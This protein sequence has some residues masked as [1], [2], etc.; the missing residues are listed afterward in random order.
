MDWLNGGST[1]FR[2]KSCGTC[3]TPISTKK[4]CSVACQ[5]DFEWL[6]KKGLVIK[7]EGNSSAV[8]RY[9][10]EQGHICN[11]CKNTIWNNV[12]IPLE[13]EHK[14]G[15]SKNNSLD[16]TELLCPNCHA[17]TPTYKNRN[18]GNGRAS[19]RKRYAEGKSY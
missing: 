8:K 6:Q 17:L 14:D 7:G 11:C 16:N 9:L 12:P 4:Y 15:N 5:K 1:N 2:S 19:R 18:R 3:Q 13:L 10:L